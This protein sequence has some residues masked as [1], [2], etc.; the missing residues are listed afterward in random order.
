GWCAFKQRAAP[1]SFAHA[2]GRSHET[3]ARWL[4]HVGFLSARASDDAV[5][6]VEQC[7]NAVRRN[8]LSIE[9]LAQRSRAELRAD[10]KLRLA[11]LDDWDGYYHEVAALCFKEVRH[12]CAAC[13]QHSARPIAI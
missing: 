13:L 11:V 9:H 12:C 10:N 8:V 3:V 2:L 6:A 4:A 7:R 5:G 1:A